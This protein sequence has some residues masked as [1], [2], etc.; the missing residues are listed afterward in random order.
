MN[1]RLKWIKEQKWFYEFRLPDGTTTES[2]LPEQVR[3]IHSTREAALRD[4]LGRPGVGGTNALDVACHEGYYT[5]VLAEYFAH[6]FGVD[7]SSRSLARARAIAAVLE[8]QAVTY[9]ESTVEQLSTEYAAD[10]VLCFGLLYH[11]ENPVEVLRRLAS[12]TRR[13]LCIETQVLPFEVSGHVEDGASVAQRALHGTFG[14]CL[15]YPDNAEGGVSD[16]ALVPSRRALEFILK[17]VGFTS[18]EFF[19]PASDAYEQ[20]VRGHRVIV[21]AQRS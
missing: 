4:F 3:G 17:R 8:R 18:V 12:L 16:L 10:F 21:L 2:Y 19:E 13:S 6:V 1:D 5:L 20:F 9:A 14:L 7:R 11:C 15:D